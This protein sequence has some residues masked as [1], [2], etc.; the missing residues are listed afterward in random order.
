MAEL[1]HIEKF[2]DKFEEEKLLLLDARSEGEFDHAHIP[3]AINVPLLNNEHRHLVGIE[4]KKKGREAAVALGF[5]LVGPLFHEFIKKANEKNRQKRSNDLLLA[6]RNAEFNHGLGF[7]NGRVS[8]F[9]V[10]GRI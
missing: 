1:I 8:G 6:R 10:K 5:E 3:G 2:L 7:I 4:Y 9:F